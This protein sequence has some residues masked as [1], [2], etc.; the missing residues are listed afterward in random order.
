M[1]EPPRRVTSASLEPAGILEAHVIVAFGGGVR[2]L[3]VGL[4]NT[5]GDEAGDWVAGDGCVPGDVLPQAAST[6]ATTISARPFLNARICAMGPVSSCGPA[7]RG[8]RP[9]C[10][11]QGTFLK[12]SRRGPTREW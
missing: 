6:T 3:S 10:R 5:N 1:P 8:V 2:P 4:G 7:R 11:R 9:A 12:P